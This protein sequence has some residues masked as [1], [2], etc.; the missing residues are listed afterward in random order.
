[1]HN[2]ETPVSVVMYA[3]D[4]RRA[5]RTDSGSLSTHA[6]EV[7]RRGLAS[8]LIQVDAVVAKSVAVSSGLPILLRY[9]ASNRTRRIIVMHLVLRLLVNF[10]A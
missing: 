8:L 4:L 2:S 1:M 5:P 7:N 6:H 10:F 3:L 9:L